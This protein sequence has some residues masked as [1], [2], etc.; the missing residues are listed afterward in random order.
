MTGCRWRSRP[1]APTTCPRGSSP[2]S[3]SPPRAASTRSCRASTCPS[4]RASA[5]T[6]RSPSSRRSAR[7]SPSSAWRTDRGLPAPRDTRFRPLQEH[8][9]RAGRGVLGGARSTLHAT[10]RSLV[11]G[12]LA[13]G[14]ARA[15]RLAVE[16]LAGRVPCRSIS[17]S[18]SGPDVLVA[19]RCRRSRP[20]G[21]RHPQRPHVA[22]PASA[23][24][25]S[26]EVER[27][28]RLDLGGQSR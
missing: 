17:S 18:R 16:A 12:D 22:S 28:P 9:A 10:H 26:R 19:W 21:R 2:R 3:R 24:A 5:S 14:L 11:S 27:R 7:R 4:S 8:V 20:A 23:G 1:T 25:G 13:L 6:R 15:G